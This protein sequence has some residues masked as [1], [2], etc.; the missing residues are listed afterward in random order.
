MVKICSNELW[1]K[2]EDMYLSKSSASQTAL[3]KQFYRLR[4]EKGMDLRIQLDAFTTLLRDVFN[5]GGKIEKDDQ[6]CLFMT[7][8]SKSYDLIMPL[9]GKKSDLT[10]SKVTTV[11]LDYESL[12]HREENVSGSSSVH[13]TALVWR[14]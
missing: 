1:M 5:T 14:C 9:L 13:V 8:L 7:S 12:R 11:L 10:M 3:K 4:L 2:L 6:A